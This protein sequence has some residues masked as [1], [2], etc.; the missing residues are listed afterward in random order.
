[1]FS[2]LFCIY[3]RYLSVIKFVLRKS[4]DFFSS[5]SFPLLLDPDPNPQ[6][7]LKIKKSRWKVPGTGTS[8]PYPA[9]K[10]NSKVKY[11]QI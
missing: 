7:F 8:Y 11:L 6:N 2:L 10:K 3:Y 1:M 5:L 9:R 4:A